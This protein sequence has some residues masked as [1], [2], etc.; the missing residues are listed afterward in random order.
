MKKILIIALILLALGAISAFFVY[1]YVYNKPHPDYVKAKAEVVVNAKQLWSDYVQDKDKADGK[2]TGKILQVE[3][4][5][6]GQEDT[7]SLLI[8]VYA[9]SQGMFGDEGI[10]V[11][12]LPEFSRSA[13]ALNPA[14]PVKIKGLC[15][16]YNGTDVILENGS[17]VGNQP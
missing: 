1:K 8:V 15:T 17:I 16:G 3:G 5:I 2:Y 9:Y 12:M 7:D 14:V 11:T 4:S 10:R 6:S 13:K